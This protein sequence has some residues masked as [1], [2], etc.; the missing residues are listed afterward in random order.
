MLHYCFSVSGNR[1]L[2]AL[3]FNPEVQPILSFWICLLSL[4]FG[5]WS[6]PGFYHLDFSR[7]Q[8]KCY[9]QISLFSLAILTSEHCTTRFSFCRHYYLHHSCRISL[10]SHA[11]F[12]CRLKESGN[13]Y[14]QPH[15]LSLVFATFAGQSPKWLTPS[16][17]CL[18]LFKELL[19]K[20]F[21]FRLLPSLSFVGLLFW[22]CYFSC[23]FKNLILPEPCFSS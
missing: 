13:T 6:V 16:L 20:H 18:Q 15:D 17:I 9:L 8:R 7:C 21:S 14:F 10:T 11:A 22:F 19:P 2:A 12:F 1:A 5:C 4:A 3:R 23:L